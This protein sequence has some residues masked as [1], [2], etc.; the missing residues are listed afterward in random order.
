AALSGGVTSGLGYAL[1]YR[2]V[3]RLAAPV[4]ATVQLSVPIIALLGG[5][6]LLGETI[7]PP[8]LAGA[9]IVLGGIALAA[10]PAG[11]G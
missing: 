4:T 3:P 7:P 8:L 6:V 2:L 1:W 10:F 5:L 9:A 11:R